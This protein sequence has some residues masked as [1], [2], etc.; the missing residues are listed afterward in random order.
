M[1]APT[2]LVIKFDDHKAYAAFWMWLCEQGEQDYGEYAD[3]Q[4][5]SPQLDFN[6]QQTDKGIVVATSN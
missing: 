6:Y 5:D 1:S 2:E 3:Y 4:D